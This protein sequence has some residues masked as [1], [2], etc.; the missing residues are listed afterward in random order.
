MR[1]FFIIFSAVYFVA[2]NIYGVILLKFQKKSIEE[3]DEDYSVSNFKILLAG[4]LG[5]A[6]GI[7]TFMFIFKYKL[8][9]IAFMILMPLFF[10]ITL[11]I[12]IL[13]IRSGYNI[14]NFNLNR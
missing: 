5:G 2:I 10:S 6:L 7:Y 14:R 8:K 12:F 13:L 4:F 1:T 9:N 11:T 3:L